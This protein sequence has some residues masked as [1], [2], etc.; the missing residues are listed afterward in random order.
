MS[1]KITLL[2]INA[3]Y[4][5]SSLAV[6]YLAEAVSQFSCSE[7]EI[8]VV[9]ATINQPDGD[10]LAQIAATTPDVLGIS[11]YIWNARKLEALLKDIRASLPDATLVLGGPEASYNAAHWLSQGADF[12]IRGEGERSFPLLLDALADGTPVN[13][14]IEAPNDT[15][16]NPYTDAYFNALNGRIAYLETSRGC[17]FQCAFCLSG[18]SRLR[19]FPLDEAKEQLYKLSKSGAKTIKLVDRTF[20]CNADRAY[21]L[22]EYVIGLDTQCCFH[23]EVAADLFDERTLSL[24]RSAPPG[25]IQLE[26]GLQSFHEPALNAVARRTSL[27]KAEQNLNILLDGRNI[28][29]HVDLIAGLPQET[30]AD[31]RRSFDRAY[32][33]GA[34]TL[35]LGFLKLLHGSALR[36][37]A[38]QWGLCYN[39]EPPYEI[40]SS[41]WLGAEELDV[42]R[43]VEHALQRVYNSGRFAETVRYVLSS[44]GIAPFE[45]YH[46]LGKFASGYGVQLDS[47]AEQCYACFAGLPGASADTLCDRMICDWLCCMRG[48]NM[49]S[50]LRIWDKQ[51]VAYAERVLGRKIERSEAAVL[52]TGEYVFIDS[53]A[54]DPVTGRYT[55]FSKL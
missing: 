47:F 18:G 25:R 16:I 54:V 7:Y 35:Q 9:E 11:A 22:F 31:F 41:P 1:N 34:H 19:F 55:L 15:I 3:K 53:D 43:Q 24:L 50:F 38:E 26:A 4:V 36:E 8:S 17:P 44:T 51:A 39:K 29:I 33:I 42:I 37:Q 5:H 52:R 48:K 6:W 45:L 49:P 10:I 23:F 21:A 40:I 2:A 13:T 12:V 28:H 14:Q 30:L 32:A 20:N 27:E 46:T